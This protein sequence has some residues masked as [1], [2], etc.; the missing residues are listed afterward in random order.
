MQGQQ[1]YNPTFVNVGEGSR[2]I[3]ISEAL[4]GFL[5]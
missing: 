2:G 1:T 5:I 3:W 4:W